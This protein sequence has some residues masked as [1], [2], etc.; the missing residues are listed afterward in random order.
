MKNSVPRNE[1]Q[2]NPHKLRASDIVYLIMLGIVAL[3]FVIA[4]V[5]YLSNNQGDL[6]D[7]VTV[8]NV[9]LDVNGDGLQDYILEMKYIENTGNLNLTPGQ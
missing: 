8:E 1:N 2:E 4:G 9:F 6:P 7:P 5:S 3:F